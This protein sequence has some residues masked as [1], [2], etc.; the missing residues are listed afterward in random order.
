MQPEIT[1]PDDVFM[2]LFCSF[3]FSQFSFVPHRFYALGGL[4]YI[5]CLLYKTLTFGTPSTATF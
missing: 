1:D 5:E 4:S 3:T 2:I